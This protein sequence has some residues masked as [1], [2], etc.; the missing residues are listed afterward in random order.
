MERHERASAAATLLE[1]DR[2]G[3]A[4]A[5]LT[6]TYPDMTVED[7]YAIQVINIRARTEAGARV[8]GR[9]VG[10][11]SRVMQEAYGVDEPDYGHVLDDMCHADGSTVGADRYLQPRVEVEIAFRLR[12]DLRGPGVTV[13]DVRAA[14]LA[15]APSIEIIASRI[16]D[17]RITLPDTIADNASSGG[18]VLGS[19]VA[20]GDA[21]ALAGVVADLS[22]GGDVVASGRGADV[23]GDPAAAVAWLANK[24]SALGVGLEA[25]QIIMPGSCTRAIAVGPGDDV[26]AEFSGLGA[27]SVGFR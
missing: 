15:V 7:A 11:T 21:P 19:W 2:T 3:R 13:D 24:M 12:A 27:V 22:V 4:V 26:R 10:L 14:T 18:I 25:D 1:A 5:P 8:V 20:L 6:A 23:L 9:K 16:A 17:W